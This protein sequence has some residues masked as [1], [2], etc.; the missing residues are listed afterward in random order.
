M[1]KRKGFFFCF[2]WFVLELASLFISK[3]SGYSFYVLT[4][5]AFSS[6]IKVFL[7]RLWFLEVFFL[8]HI[9]IK[10]IKANIKRSI[11]DSRQV[12]SHSRA[13]CGS[14]MAMTSAANAPKMQKWNI[15]PIMLPRQ[16]VELSSSLRASSSKSIFSRRCAC[17]CRKISKCAI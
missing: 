9:N 16:S 8:E 13:V 1:Q 3:S 14:V 12:V 5:C 4:V 17:I 2:R 6:E 10:Y 15:K 11:L 7:Y